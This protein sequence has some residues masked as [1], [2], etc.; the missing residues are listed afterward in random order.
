M[1]ASEVWMSDEA[2]DSVEACA[3]PGVGVLGGS[4]AGSEAGGFDATPAGD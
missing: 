4:E 3:L 2:Q 1:P